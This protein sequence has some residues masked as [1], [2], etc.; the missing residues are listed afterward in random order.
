MG[1]E[2]TYETTCIL[3]RIKKCNIKNIDKLLL[4]LNPDK[5]EENVNKK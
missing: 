2:K 1:F 3:A 5:N 4:K